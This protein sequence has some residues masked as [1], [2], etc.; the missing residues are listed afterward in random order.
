MRGEGQGGRR[1]YGRNWKGKEGRRRDGRQ[2]KEN[3]GEEEPRGTGSS[4]ETKN[5]RK[6]DHFSLRG[7]FTH[8]TPSPVRAKFGVAWVCEPPAVP[9]F[10]LICIVV[11]SAWCNAAEIRRFWLYFEV[12]GF[13]YP[14]PHRS[15]LN[16]ARENK[17]IPAVQYFMPYFALIC[18][19]AYCR[20]RSEKPRF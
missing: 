14:C 20:S 4:W 1:R 15:G 8:P 16:L 5:R 2:G 18:I 7:L 6:F 10:S 11:A 17:L 19:Y 3:K 13:Q 12:R 9:Y